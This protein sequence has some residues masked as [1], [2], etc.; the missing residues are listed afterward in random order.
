MDRNLAYTK[1]H[2]RRVDHWLVVIARP[3]PQRSCSPSNPNLSGKWPFCGLLDRTNINLQL[4]EAPVQ[5]LLNLYREDAEVFDRLSRATQKPVRFTSADASVAPK[6]FAAW[7]QLPSVS[8]K[9]L[10][11]F[12]LVARR[13]WRGRLALTHS[14]PHK[15]IK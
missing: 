11:R 3:N 5:T 9:S 4:T 6:N 15:L 12:L 13:A 14:T 1:P 2:Y 10:R 7:R 8:Q